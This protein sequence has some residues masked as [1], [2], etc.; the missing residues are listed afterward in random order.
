[1]ASRAAQMIRTFGF[2]VYVY[3]AYNWKGCTISRAI[4]KAKG[5]AH[6]VELLCHLRLRKA[7]GGCF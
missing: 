1:V 5:P 2:A 6:S 4:C 7:L 3:C